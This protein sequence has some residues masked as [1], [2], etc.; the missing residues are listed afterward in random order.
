MIIIHG[1]SIRPLRCGFRVRV[2]RP[3]RE[4]IAFRC[5]ECICTLDGHGFVDLQLRLAI[6]GF[7]HIACAA[8]RVPPDMRR[9]R[10]LER[11]ILGAK[12]HR[13]LHCVRI[14]FRWCRFR[15]CIVF[16]NNEVISREYACLCVFVFVRLGIPLL[17]DPAD[18]LFFALVFCCGGRLCYRFRTIKIE[19]VVGRRILAAIRIIYDIDALGSIQCL[20]PFCIEIEFFIDPETIVARVAIS[21]RVC[22]LIVVTRRIAI[23]IKLCRLSTV[24]VCCDCAVIYNKCIKDERSFELFIIVPAYQLIAEPRSVDCLTIRDL[25]TITNLETGLLVFSGAPFKIGLRRIYIWVK[26]YTIFLLDP[27]GV[28][29]QTAFRQCGKC[30]G[31]R[32]GLVQIPASELVREVRVRNRCRFSRIVIL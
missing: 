31:N 26:E 21:I 29:R 30:A 10:C 14:G 20:A 19:S 22:I 8:I 23:L 11:T 1:R 24:I 16:Q 32:T 27:F 3:A 17:D 4:F 7:L 6:I 18:K 25:L 15:S 5:C 13:V 2:T 28:Y 9:C 12:L